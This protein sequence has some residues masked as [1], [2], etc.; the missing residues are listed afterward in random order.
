[1]QN[2]LIYTKINIKVAESG[3]KWLKVGYLSPET[4]RRESLQRGNASKRE[5]FQKGKASA[6]CKAV[7]VMFM[8]EYNHTIDA[9]GRLI[10][11]ARFRESLG[12]EFVVTKGLDGCLFAYDNQEWNAFEEKLK[13][14]PLSRKDNRQFARFFL[15]GAAPVE[16]DKQGRI[17]IPANLRDFAGLVK[18]VVMVGVASRIEIWS[19]EK[20]EALQ[21][22][23]E[24]SVEDIAE[25]M[26]ELGLGI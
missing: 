24:E 6:A 3:S 16:V 26:S 4:A 10:I 1:M 14:L 19:R 2:P 20:W 8:G 23:E 9:K 22:E 11:P 25:R 5:S 13:A 7:I 18:D 12:E 15:A 17:L 21:E